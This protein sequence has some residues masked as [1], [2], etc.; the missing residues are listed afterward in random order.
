[1]VH[2]WLSVLQT[3]APRD[4]A[5]PGPRPRV[6]RRNAAT[7]AVLQPLENRTLM[8]GDGLTP[9]FDSYRD[10][11]YATVFPGA[12]APASDAVAP[13]YT[14][15][16]ATETFLNRGDGN[17][18][19]RADLV[20][21]EYRWSIDGNA[22]AQRDGGGRLVRD[23]V[24][25]TTNAE[26]L[27]V[28]HVFDEAGVYTVTLDVSLTHADGVVHRASTSQTI[29]IDHEVPRGFTADSFRNDRLW[30]RDVD[31]AEYRL[32]GGSAADAARLAAAAPAGVRIS[33]YSAGNF[34]H[35]FRDDL[36]GVRVYFN[37][38]ETYTFDN[39]NGLID[40]PDADDLYIGAYGNASAA[41]RLDVADNY[42]N[43]GGGSEG[44][45]RVL[46]GSNGVTIEGLNLEGRGDNNNLSTGNGGDGLAADL[47]R[48]GSEE[49]LLSGVV[50]YD[51]R[52]VLLRDLDISRV[53][54]HGVQ[55]SGEG[56]DG[57]GIFDSTLHDLSRYGAYLGVDNGSALAGGST[58]GNFSVSGSHFYNLSG[59]EHGVR[60]QGLTPSSVDDDKPF[61]NNVYIANNVIE[62]RPEAP[63][64]TAIQVRGNTQHIVI[65]GNT[66]DRVIG[67]QPQNRTHGAYEQIRLAQVFD[68]YVG[69]SRAAFPG[70][71]DDHAHGYFAFQIYADDVSVRQNIA[72]DF[73]IGF[74]IAG[75]R[76]GNNPIA[77]RARNNV[78]VDGNV[79]LNRDRAGLRN[80]EYT[81]RDSRLASFEHLN[82]VTLTNN[83]S[84]NVSFTGRGIDHLESVAGQ[85]NRGPAPQQSGNAL[86]QT[87][88]GLPSG[89][90]PTRSI[91]DAASTLRERLF[92]AGTAIPATPTAPDAP[93]SPNAPA[94]PASPNAP[95]APID[96]DP[97]EQNNTP[98]S[99]FALGGSSLSSFR[100]PALTD[101]NRGGDYYRLNHDGGDLNLTLDADR[102]VAVQLFAGTG[103]TIHRNGQID[104]QRENNGAQG[105]S[106][107]SAGVYTVLVYGRGSGGTPYDLTWDTR[108]TPSPPAT[109][110]PDAA[111]TPNA[112]PDAYESN[113]N[114]GE[115]SRLSGRTGSLDTASGWATVDADR[116]GDYYAID[117]GGGPLAL[118]LTTTD[119]DTTGLG[120]ELYR[121]VSSNLHANAPLRPDRTGG[122]GNSVQR[123]DNLNG[124]QYTVLVYGS[125]AAEG[126]GYN[127]DW[128]QA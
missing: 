91:I 101:V 11:E 58:F 6:V 26:G 42:R 71:G 77:G 16:D 82:R 128:S 43:S 116:R 78:F 87:L 80:S 20:N 14:V 124:G 102:P 41:P 57:L 74:D 5:E 67:L 13:F 81:F 72:D 56:T 52:S 47:K 3:A 68:N 25:N 37:R 15:F 83:Q 64:K 104:P 49:G 34:S 7:A 100:G 54:Q 123:W 19:Q 33:H 18:Q 27:V 61:L 103:N 40:L 111:P 105:W 38:G 86:G 90:N 70:T 22:A 126:L 8:S 24:G 35:A 94:A 118:R 39:R 107:L 122:A 121:G 73:N 17:E 45:F 4:T 95:A 112:G 92:G 50:S 79:L 28:G 48:S 9:Q 63:S 108:A 75:S 120:L 66:A 12:A 65:D 59:G 29:Q 84:F 31:G 32:I 127:L 106:N 30:E 97:Y 23:V 117:V 98:G 76:T 60:V 53:S 69:L 2:A 85:S 21:A 113:N 96:G 62:T 114:P 115:A 44:I 46:N 125:H 109:P 88:T 99:A 1:V 10:D 36:D 119:P 93:A 89:A 51:A 110:T 55:T